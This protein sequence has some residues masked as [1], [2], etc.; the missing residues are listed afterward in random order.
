MLLTAKEVHHISLNHF[1]EVARSGHIDTAGTWGRQ[2]YQGP[3]YFN[4][5]KTSEQPLS[6]FFFFLHDFNQF[7]YEHGHERRV[8]ALKSTIK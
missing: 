6:F 4:W 2:N 3:N 5:W 1:L 8:T 7:I